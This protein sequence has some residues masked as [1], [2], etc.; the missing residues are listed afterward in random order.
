MHYVYFH[1]NPITNQ[2]FYVG[3]GVGKRAWDKKHGRSKH[4]YN[5]IKKYGN[6][7]IKIVH[8]NLYFEQAAE[9]EKYYISL[10]GRKGYE[11]NGILLNKSKGGESGSKGCKWSKEAIEKR[12]NKLK[13]KIFNNEHKNKISQSKIN[14][15]SYK[16]RKSNKSITQSSLD[17][18]I[19]KIWNTIKDASKELNIGEQYIIHCCKNRRES[20]KGY[21]WKYI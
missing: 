2:I 6:P 3:L 1:I 12:N 20:Y 10:L 8:Q 7:I 17:G 5:Y 18:N 16:N 15:P 21:L 13:G 4:W 9:Y 11:L 14:H 19:I